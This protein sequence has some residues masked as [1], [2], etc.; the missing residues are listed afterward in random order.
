MVRRYELRERA[1]RQAHT[2]R[3]IIEATV[4]LHVERGPAATQVTD[5]AQRAGVD[6][7]TIY[8]HFPDPGSLLQACSA[9]YYSV[10]PLPDPTTWATI[11]DPDA[12]MRHGLR[13]LYAYWAENAAMVANILRDAQVLGHL[14]VGR[15]LLALQRDSVEVLARGWSAPNKR[16]AA[17]AATIRTAVDFQT[18]QRLVREYGLSVQAAIELA[19]TW[20]HCAAIAP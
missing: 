1:Q 6:R 13:E 16:E 2:R 12:R 9:Y 18:W 20:T 5:I 17:V 19:V 14:G 4:A 7:V 8:R 3:R 11:E 10:H 15:R